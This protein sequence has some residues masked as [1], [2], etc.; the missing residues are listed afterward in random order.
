[1]NWQRI[2][3]KLIRHA[4]ERGVVGGYS[5]CHHIIPK[6]HGGT[7]NPDNLVQLTAREHFVAHWLLWRIHRD[8]ATALAFRLLCDTAGKP[9]GRSYAAAKAI[10]A[11]AMLGDANVA[12]RQEVRWRLLWSQDQGAAIA[13]EVDEGRVGYQVWQAF[14]SRPQGHRGT[15]SPQEGTSGFESAGICCY[16]QGEA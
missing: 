7:N 1:M 4:Q 9:R 11:N 16:N 2:Y 14:Y 15:L 10:Y 8:R 13:V 5:E 6:A 3:E 12:K